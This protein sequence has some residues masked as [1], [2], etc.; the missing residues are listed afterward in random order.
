MDL[1]VVVSSTGFPG[2]SLVKDLPATQEMCV[3]SLGR[4]D[5]SE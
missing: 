2:G 1:G 5:P 4:E 3:Q